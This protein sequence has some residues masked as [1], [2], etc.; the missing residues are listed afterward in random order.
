MKDYIIQYICAVFGGLLAFLYGDMPPAFFALI[1][2]ICLD[3]ATGLSHAWVEK[4]LNSRV[5]GRGILKKVY[6]LTLVAVGHLVD[7]CIGKSVC[8]NVVIF[9]YIA[10]E[11]I[12]IVE[13]AGRCGLPVPEKLA[14]VL[15][16][17]KEGGHGD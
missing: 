10:N 4:K 3:F 16:Q 17:L 15:E 6:I 7:V 14:E 13:N 1:A 8:M 9:F 11:A 12:S 5:C 2:L